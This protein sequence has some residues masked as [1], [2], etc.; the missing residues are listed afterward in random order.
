MAA[1]VVIVDDDPDVLELI[2]ALL[3]E[4]GYQTIICS[5][6]LAALQA[7]NTHRPALAI[8]DLTMPIM[9]GYDLIE[10]LRD[11]PGQPLPIIAISSAMYA[12]SPDQLQVDA[13]L[14]K[15]F[16]LEE[17][18]AQ[19]TYL[20]HRHSESAAASIEEMTVLAPLRNSAS[21]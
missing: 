2:S 16:D 20:A 12:P 4:E 13:Y 1:K 8:I 11:M 10:R 17:L 14:S 7:I 15:P 19:V 21:H 18:L 3:D 9:T 6:G 5:D